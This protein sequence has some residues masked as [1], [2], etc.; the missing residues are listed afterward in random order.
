[1]WKVLNP[2]HQNQTSP[3]LNHAILQE[4][5]DYIMG[6]LSVFYREKRVFFLHFLPSTLDAEGEICI[7]CQSLFSVR[8]R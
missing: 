7:N 2:C 8:R 4:K 3:S 6:L 5:D 1:M